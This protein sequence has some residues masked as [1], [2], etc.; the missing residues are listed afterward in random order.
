MVWTVRS[1][2]LRSLGR[3]GLASI[4]ALSALAGTSVQART[5]VDDPTPVV[6]SALPA[7]AQQTLRL[8]R[9][10]GPFP[11]S[12]DGTVFGNRERL[13]PRRERGYYREYTVRAPGTRNRGARRIVCGGSPPTK[14]ETCYY[15]QDHYVSF[16][17]ITS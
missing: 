5:S 16:Q 11:Y 13:L 10:G 7:E 8:I 2:L 4:I 3:L 6:E 14:P 1:S 12:K 15:T 9:S 17:R